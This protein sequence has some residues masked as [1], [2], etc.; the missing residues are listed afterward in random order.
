[1]SCRHSI[2]PRKPR[3]S[4]GKVMSEK[5]LSDA[6]FR[7]RARLEEREAEDPLRLFEELRRQLKALVE[8][9]L[10]SSRDAQIYALAEHQKL[11]QAGLMSQTEMKVRR[12]RMNAA[13][14][15]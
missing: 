8:E 14:D 5:G 15:G 11:M 7:R 4:K 12:E 13:L 2:F 1:M 3:T 10:V 6:R 9:G